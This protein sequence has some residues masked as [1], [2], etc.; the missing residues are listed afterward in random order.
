MTSDDLDHNDELLAQG[1]R[2]KLEWVTPKMSEMDTKLVACK[3]P[4]L[5]LENLYPHLLFTSCGPS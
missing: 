2:E 3:V 4:G 1:K 5:L